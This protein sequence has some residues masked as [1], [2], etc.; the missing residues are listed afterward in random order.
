LLPASLLPFRA[1]VPAIG[2]GQNAVIALSAAGDPKQSLT[3]VRRAAGSSRQIGG[4]TIKADDFQ[5]PA[6]SGEPDQ[7]VVACNLLAK[8][9]CRLSLGDEPP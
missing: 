8:D 1:G 2:V 3:E 5:T 6:N 4:P 7:A 9:D